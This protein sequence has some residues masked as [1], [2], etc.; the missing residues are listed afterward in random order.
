MTVIFNCRSFSEPPKDLQTLL[1]DKMY[2]WDDLR[3]ACREIATRLVIKHCEQN[4]LKKAHNARIDD[5][6]YNQRSISETIFWMLKD[7]GEKLH[8]WS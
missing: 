5:D 1:A 6:V 3:T 8:S 7:E 4:A 2:S